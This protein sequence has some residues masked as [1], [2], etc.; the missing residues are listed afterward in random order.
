MQHL[1][2]EA[3][4]HSCELGARQRVEPGNARVAG[5]SVPIGPGQQ[6][7]TV[8]PIG[9]VGGDQ[10]IGVIGESHLGAGR[11]GTDADTA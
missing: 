3:D 9:H 11:H 4:A 5:E 7:L 8:S 6:E 2:G 1:P 10:S